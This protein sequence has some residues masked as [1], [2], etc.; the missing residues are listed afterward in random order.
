[1]SNKN[2]GIKKQHPISAP[3]LDIPVYVKVLI[4]AQ[5]PSHWRLQCGGGGGAI[6]TCQIFC[7]SLA[8]A[9]AARYGG[10]VSGVWPD[11]SR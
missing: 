3:I 6:C 4:T 2:D 8:A 9:A 1:M 5:H 7:I 10:G 11:Q